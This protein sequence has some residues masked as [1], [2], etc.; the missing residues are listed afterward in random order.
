MGVLAD[1][2]KAAIDQMRAVNEREAAATREFIATATAH[3]EAMQRGLD[4]LTDDADPIAD[5][6]ALLRSEGWELI[7]PRN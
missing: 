2:M 6:I 5:A 3:C 4:E 7:P 1:Q